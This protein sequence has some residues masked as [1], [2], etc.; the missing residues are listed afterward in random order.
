MG[1]N[2]NETDR[3]EMHA[4]PIDACPTTS[5]HLYL[6]KTKILHG[7]TNHEH[8]ERGNC[9]WTDVM[10]CLTPSPCIIKFS[11]PFLVQ[12]LVFSMS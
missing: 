8:L 7:Q 2:D 9:L 4:S 1:T 12:D 6:T 5:G 11:N 10:G 3:I